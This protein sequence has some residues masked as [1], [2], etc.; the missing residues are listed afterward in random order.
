MRMGLSLRGWRFFLALGA[1]GTANCEGGTVV[2][3]TK[4]LKE[5]TRFG[6]ERGEGE[7]G[8]VG[9]GEFDFEV[10]SRNAGPRDGDRDKDRRS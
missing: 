10:M 2:V 9:E 7:S 8:E 5:L 3:D 4:R 1:N 6:G